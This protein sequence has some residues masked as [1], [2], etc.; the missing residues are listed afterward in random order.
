MIIFNSPNLVSNDIFDELKNKNFFNWKTFKEVWELYLNLAKMKNRV[1]GIPKFRMGENEINVMSIRNNKEIF[2]NES[3]YFYNDLL[4][5]HL[6]PINFYVFKVT[7]DPKGKVNKIA[8]L[9]EGIYASYKANRP[10][11]WVP[12]RTAIVQDRDVVLVARTDLSGNITINEHKGFFGINIHDSDKYL[13]SS[14]GCTVLERDSVQNDFHFKN[15]FKPLI[16]SI[17]NKESIDYCLIN[18]MSLREI[19]NSI[20]NNEKIPISIFDWAFSANKFVK[21]PIIV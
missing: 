13:N 18:I 14:M 15:H 7:T 1:V 21:N 20:Q 8:H 6:N 4:I 11:R 5:I 16:K 10:H 12:G 2:F 3:Q 17:A 9:L 19:L